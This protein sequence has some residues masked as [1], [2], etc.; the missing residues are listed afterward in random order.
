MW[1]AAWEGISD[2]LWTL[3]VCGAVVSV[4]LIA[5]LAK[6]M[7]EQ[8]ERPRW[9]LWWGAAG[10]VVGLAL[11]GAI[12][13]NGK[14]CTTG[15]DPFGGCDEWEYPYQPATAADRMET[16]AYVLVLVGI[17]AMIG[18]WPEKP[19]PSIEEVHERLR[20]SL[21]AGS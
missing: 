14:R 1:P 8:S 20:R 21:E 6:E 17:P 2:A 11:L 10:M 3:M 16:F 7:F 9:L 13:T 19:K 15:T 5:R 4:H 12:E 18:I